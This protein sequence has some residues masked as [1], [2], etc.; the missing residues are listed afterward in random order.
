[1]FFR[2]G[3]KLLMQT[4]VE[5]CTVEL[6]QVHALRQLRADAL[7]LPS[8]RLLWMG[9]R[10]AKRVRDEAG[11]MVEEGARRHPRSPWAQLSARAADYCLSATSYTPTS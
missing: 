10:V 3:A 2:R 9:A 1:M 4:Q 6:Y 11:D 8:N 5:G 7:I